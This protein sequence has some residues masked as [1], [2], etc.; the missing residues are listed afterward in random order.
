MT[1]TA[2]LARHATIRGW[3]AA[4][5][6]AIAPHFPLETFIARNPVA[7]YET[8]DHDDALR[9][10]AQEHG[11]FLTPTEERFRALHAEGRIPLSDLVAALHQFVP[12]ARSLHPVVTDGVVTT[13]S[14]V[15]LHDLLVSPPATPL[16]TSLPTPAHTLSP[17]VHARVDDLTSRWLTA[18]F[19]AAAWSEP[20][21]REGMWNSWRR[22]AALDPTLPRRVR[23]GIRS[24]PAEPAAAI[25][26]ALEWWSLDG[27][28]AED[29]IRAHV[30][31]QPGWS[32]LVRH[33]AVE[34]RSV[35]LASL[36]AIRVTLEHLLLPADATFPAAPAVPPADKE[37]RLRAVADGIGADASTPDVRATLQ[38]ILS[39]ID[40]LTRLSIWQEAYERGAARALAPASAPVLRPLGDAARSLAQAI[41]CIDT[42]SE[43]Y[44]RHLEAA[45]P[46]ETLG[47]AGFFAVPISFR[48][49]DGSPEVASCPV[50]LTPRVAVTES[51]VDRGAIDRWRRQR[52]ATAEHCGA[53]HALGE[54]TLAP[55]AFAETAGWFLGAA[56]VA[57]TI[58]PRLWNSARAGIR[59][60]KPATRVNADV[61][62][63]LDE[64]VLYAETALRMMGLVDGFAPIVLICGHGAS[65]T[66]N[67]FASG[68]QCGACGGHE[69]EPNA[70][71]AATIFNDPATRD[72]L[73]ARGI[74]I[75]DDTLFVAAQM[76][77]VTDEV[78]I[79][80]PWTIPASHETRILELARHL[81][82]ARAADAAER[83]ATLPGARPNTDAVTETL[84]RSSDW[85]E[86]FPEWGL[87]GNAAFIVG[88][89]AITAGVDLGRRTFLHSYDADA[90]PG[91]SGLE[92]ILTAPMVVAQWINA[93]YTVSTVAPDRF[94]AGPK[95]LHNVVGTAGVLSG[96]GGDLRIGLPW[97]SVGVGHETRH[98]PVR[99]QVFVQAPLTRINEIIDS[100]ET[101]R[102]LVKNRWI[103]LR[104]REYDT[105]R[106]MRFGRYGW[107]TEDLGTARVAGT[108]AGDE[109]ITTK[110]NHA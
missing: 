107:E 21:Q 76:D 77:T 39:L 66:N 54:S 57:R 70:R 38:R 17:K 29:F 41:F 8:L 86:A 15:L 20:T 83:T 61:V 105:A 98:E 110:E 73:A 81:E 95:P 89:R 23:A 80:E 50:L 7:G 79:L 96:F 5:G 19:G 99:L 33:T 12:E 36:V 84:R 55:Y 74:T 71:A 32:A 48:A 1:T 106:W 2:T 16:G 67:P 65:V 108:S 88:P 24:A 44:R 18:I 26:T 102:N 100:S 97:Q 52:T 75:P 28:A 72:G 60:P 90:D 109:E 14:E 42:R 45:G 53:T 58:A 30:L 25:N 62:F 63:S 46:I 31:A 59:R 6:R 93:Q 51:S 43:S 49:A 27:W 78:R 68:L 22:L 35:D 3:V 40:P 104:A 64:R 37:G 87:A 47:F 13:L 82:T 101:V 10:I 85:A 56:S 69:G 11:V 4:S 9:L 94:G 103:T 34:S 91:G 92:T